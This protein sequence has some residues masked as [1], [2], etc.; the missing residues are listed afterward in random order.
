MEYNIS[1]LINITILL[2]NT[3]TI[4]VRGGKN[5][6]DFFKGIESL[7]IGLWD[8]LYRFICNLTDKEEKKDSLIAPLAGDEE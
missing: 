7:L 2:I 1:G 3:K 5:M 8:Y 4:F 6:S